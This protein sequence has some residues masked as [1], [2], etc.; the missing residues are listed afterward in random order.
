[1]RPSDALCCRIDCSAPIRLSKVVAPSLANHALVCR[2]GHHQLGHPCHGRGRS[3]PLGQAD[4]HMHQVKV[5]A[6]HRVTALS[7]GRTRR[8]REGAPPDRVA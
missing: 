2:V 1:M 6:V 5:N 4:E 8:A 3:L 7:P